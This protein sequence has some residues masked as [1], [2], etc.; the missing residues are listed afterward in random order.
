M[1]LNKS[2]FYGAALVSMFFLANPAIAT[3]IIDDQFDDGN[4]ATNTAGP[5]TGWNVYSQGS[6][7]ASEGGGHAHLNSVASPQIIQISSK[8]TFDFFNANG[9]NAEWEITSSG[10]GAT[11]GNRRYL[12]V[13][14][15]DFSSFDSRLNPDD[16]NAPGVYVRLTDGGDY[17]GGIEIESGSGGGRQLLESWSWSS[18]WDGSG[19]LDVDL[20]L[21]D[22][23]Y[24]LDIAGNVGVYNSAGSWSSL[25]GAAAT[26]TSVWGSRSAVIA[27]QNQ[28][29]PTSSVLA[30]DRIAVSTGVPV[31]APASL[32]L[33]ALALFGL[34]FFRR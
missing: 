32:G 20:F 15:E 27:A 18:I 2:T 9:I 28:A 4:L 34:R 29:L 14:A 7:T 5:G 1:Q 12:S 10:A 30:I 19:A 16:T 25:T 11:S 22:M 8:D 33:F 6:A 21:N 31:P 24:S 23:G 26:F 13:V 17:Q 3:P